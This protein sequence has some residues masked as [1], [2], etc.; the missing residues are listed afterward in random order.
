[1]SI[2]RRKLPNGKKAKT[3]TA[4]FRYAGCLYRQGGFISR[5]IAKDWCSV[6][7]TRLQRGERGVSKD[8]VHKFVAPLIEEFTGRLTH[9]GRDSMY[10]YT[11]GKRL[12]RLA[13][14]CGWLQIVHIKVESLNAWVASRP[15]WRGKLITNRTIRQF[16]DTAREFGAWLHRPKRL[17]NANPLE[18]MERPT[19]TPNTFYRRSATMDEIQRLV[20]HAPKDR[21]RFYMFLLYSPLRMKAIKGLVWDDLRLDLERPVVQVRAEIDKN[22]KGQQLPLRLDV[23]QSLRLARGKARGGDKVFPAVPT[24]DDL[25]SDLVAAG[26]PFSDAKGNRRLDRHAFRRTLISFMKSA[27]VSMDVAHQ[28]LGHRDKRTTEK[29]YDDS[30]A[31]APISNAMESLPGITAMRIV[32]GEK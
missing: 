18:D 30:L 4:E 10:V 1:M 3:Y 22:R 14:D 21:Q 16:I 8:Q 26:V 2:Y 17:L 31:N 9:Q 27:G 15:K 12:T 25:R 28:A 24:M 19:A 23:A 29:W 11:T 32:G 13:T 7:R 5:E 20:A 6:E